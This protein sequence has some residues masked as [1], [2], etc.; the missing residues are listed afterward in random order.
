MKQF[1]E[2]FRS[3][4]RIDAKAVRYPNEAW[5]AYYHVMLEN[6]ELLSDMPDVETV[7]QAVRSVFRNVEW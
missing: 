1:E 2:E 4:I 6:P 7:N 3:M 5:N